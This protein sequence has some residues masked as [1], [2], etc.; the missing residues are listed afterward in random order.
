MKHPRCSTKDMIDYIKPFARKKLDTILLHVGKNDLTKGIN[1]M[2]N[3][4]KCVKAI[5]ELDNSE[6]IQI[7]FSS[8]MN[9][10]DE[11]FQKKLVK[12]MLSCLGIVWGE[13]LFM[14]TTRILMN[15]V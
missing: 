3:I 15:L 2:K 14:L 7:G 1:T 13:D 12:A 8:I 11:N 5:R 10:S 4:K 9:R 6:Y